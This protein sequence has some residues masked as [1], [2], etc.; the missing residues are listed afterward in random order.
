VLLALASRPE[1]AA[2]RL[3]HHAAG[4]E[5]PDA[6]VRYATEAAAQAAAVGALRESASHYAAAL[7]H[8]ETLA[9]QHR[10]ELQE[11]LSYEYYLTDRIEPSLDARLAALQHWTA[12]GN[13]LKRGD[14][15][16]WLSRLSWFMGRRADAERYS[17]DAI[18][19]LVALP[20]GQ[21]LALAYSNQAQLDM[22]AYRAEPAVAWATRAIDLAEA[23][24]DDEVLC[25]ALNNR[26]AAL[27]NGHDREGQDDLER[28]LRIA[29]DHNFPEHAARAYTNL[30]SA[31]VSAHQYEEARCYSAKA[32]G[33]A[34]RSRLV[35]VLHARLARA[36]AFRMRCVARR[37]RCDR[38]GPRREHLA[39]YPL[40]GTGHA[41]APAAAAGR[42]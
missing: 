5:D 29:L 28:S 40:A 20:V 39:G 36:R 7:R 10:A 12:L 24:H 6:V 23:M 42:S 37:R 34:T 3:A 4:A 21:E 25:H 27:R 30:A 22:L 41:R 15:Q 33:T 32:S 14:A 38:D 31:T 2:A 19:T 16:R 1:I 11:R 17:R 35:A 9:L 8:G 18:E 26:G 13:D